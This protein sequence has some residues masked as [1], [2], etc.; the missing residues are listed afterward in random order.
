[1]NCEET[2]LRAVR[3]IFSRDGVE[4]VEG[5]RGKAWVTSA[6]R[7]GRTGSRYRDVGRWKGKE[8]STEGVDV[9]EDALRHGSGTQTSRGKYVRWSLNILR[10]L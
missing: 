1:M 4:V 5:Y 7:A 10:V 6:A 9:T 3:N 2:K 8:K